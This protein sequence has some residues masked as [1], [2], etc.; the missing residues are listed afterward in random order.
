MKQDAVDRVPVSLL[1]PRTLREL[2]I[3]GA[4]RPSC[5]DKSIPVQLN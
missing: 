3:S 5:L 2:R 4:L 1:R